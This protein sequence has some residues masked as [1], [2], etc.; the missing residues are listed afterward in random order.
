MD[1]GNALADRVGEEAVDELYDRR[2]LDLDLKSGEALLLVLLF[3]KLEILFEKVAEKIVD[4]VLGD[5]VVLLQML[6]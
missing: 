4:L 3:D 2:V 5:F 1:V 6:A